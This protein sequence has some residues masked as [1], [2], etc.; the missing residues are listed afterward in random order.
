MD[1][2]LLKGLTFFTHAGCT[3]EERKVGQHLEFDVELHADLGA[4]SRED[5]IRKSIDYAAVY[6]AVEGAVAQREQF[7]IEAL[8]ERAAEACR[9]FA[10][11]RVVVRVRKHAPP[12]P[13]G[14]AEYAEVEI[15]REFGDARAPGGA[16]ER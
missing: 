14:R 7:L 3:A 5:D 13:D 2:I 8:A 11:A 15:V 10:P 6:R 4:A 12:F 16:G 9:P 1:R